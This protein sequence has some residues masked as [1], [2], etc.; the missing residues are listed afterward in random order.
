MNKRRDLIQKLFQGAVIFLLVGFF[1][2]IISD[3][4]DYLN[5]PIL[6]ATGVV[7]EK[8]ISPGHEERH[9]IIAGRV[10]VPMVTHVP[11]KYIITVSL[12]NLTG[13]ILV[14]ESDY[15]SLKV[16]QSVPISYQE[17]TTNFYIDG[18]K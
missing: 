6:H 1:A 3:L 18:P 16:G 10:P 15:N 13:K 14:S 5:R 17:G 9:V 7:T 4:R 8:K 2:F 11:A 12:N